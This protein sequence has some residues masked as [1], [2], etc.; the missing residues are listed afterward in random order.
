M[1]VLQAVDRE[2]L[3]RPKSPRVIWLRNQK[4]KN[5]TVIL[6]A[7]YIHSMAN[8]HILLRWLRNISQLSFPVFTTYNFK[9]V[10]LLFTKKKEEKIKM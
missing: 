5:F 2:F 3:L 4:M 10:H 1:S 6:T 9:F 7:T 8:E